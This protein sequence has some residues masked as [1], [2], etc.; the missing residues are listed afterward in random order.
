MCRRAA[1]LFKIKPGVPGRPLQRGNQ[2]LRGGLRRTVSQGGQG[3]VH[4]VH[5]G[6]GGHQQD[7][8]SGA[9]GV[10]G[11]QMDGDGDRLL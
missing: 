3:G 9:C 2:R 10:V 4:H 1:H 6:K 11:M 8:I 5:A 7:H